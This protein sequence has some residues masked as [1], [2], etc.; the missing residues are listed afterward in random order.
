M[1]RIVSLVPAATEIVCVLGA[2]DSLVGV[3]HECDYPPLVT[4]L[5]RVTVTPI[6]QSRSGAEI[7]A[8]VRALRAAG[9]PVI[10]VDRDQLRALA[11]DVILT[12]DLCEVCA[13]ADGEVHR[14]AN[15]LDPLPRMISLAARDLAGIWRDIGT[16][17]AA[18]GREGAAATLV[19]DLKTRL[20]R[21]AK[22]AAASRPRVICIEWID[23]VY[24]AGH[25]VPELIGAAGGDDVGA[26]AG[27]HSVVTSWEEVA[28]RA[29]E[30]VIVA[31]CGFGIERAFKEL[32]GLADN[33]WLN[34]M[35]CPVWVLDGNAFTS[36][37]GP[38]VV[39]G[40]ELINS[41]L[42]GIARP[43][44]ARYEKTALWSNPS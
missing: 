14:L 12:Q 25:W 18:I 20:A 10:E 31:I 34:L 15:T 35:S 11:P 27:S 5:P 6:D 22:D 24:L 19:A 42:S 13:V 1:T 17:G 41:A 37:P 26:A 2:M 40:A 39:E 33:H 28:V 4:R 43:G 38:R 3:S 29:P 23:P 32:A 21:L 7:D 16:V 9:R 44:L 8:E 36:R 30:L